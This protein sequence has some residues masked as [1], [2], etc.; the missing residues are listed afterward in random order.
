MTVYDK[1]YI[2]ENIFWGKECECLIGFLD[3]LV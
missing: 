3:G 2:F 1:P